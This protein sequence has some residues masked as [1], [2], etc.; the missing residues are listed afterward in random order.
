MNSLIHVYLFYYNITVKSI[1]T[2]GVHHSASVLISGR[3]PIQME[4]RGVPNVQ[5]GIPVEAA[6]YESIH[7]GHARGTG[8]RRLYGESGRTTDSLRAQKGATHRQV[9]GTKHL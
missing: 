1:N 6:A 4:D 8:T 9:R 7:T 3:F 2:I 5:G